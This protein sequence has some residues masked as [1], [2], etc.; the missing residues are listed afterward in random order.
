MCR[1][2]CSSNIYGGR[3]VL[4]A[5]E[6]WF[7]PLSLTFPSKGCVGPRHER[8]TMLKEL[9]LWFNRADEL[10]PLVYRQ[11]RHQ[12]YFAYSIIY[13][14]LRYHTFC[15]G[16]VPKQLTDEHKRARAVMCM[17][18]L[19]WCHEE[20]EVF[21]QRIVTGDKTWVHHHENASKRQ[22][23]EWKHTSLPSTKKFKICQQS[24]VDAVLGL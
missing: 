6:T 2:P 13:E 1:L 21:L 16:L 4:V 24:D 7:I 11:V 8:R 10:L 3:I 15:A 5:Q 23:M 18:I 9:I 17:Q 20:G 14:V 22:S 12:L 19:K